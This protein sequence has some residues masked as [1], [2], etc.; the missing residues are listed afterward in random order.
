MYEV[1]S[2]GKDIL[3][4]EILHDVLHDSLSML[5]FLFITYILLEFI[6]HRGFYQ[7][8]QSFLSRRWLGPLLG[9]TLGIIPQCGFSLIASS[10]YVEGALSLG[11]LLAVFISTSDEAIPI[12]LAHPQQASLLP[13]IIFIKLIVA[14]IVGYGVDAL[15]KKKRVRTISMEYHDHTS[16]HGEHASLWK[17][18]MYRTMKIFMF[19]LVINLILTS[20]ITWIGEDT[21]AKLVMDKSF[22]QPFFASLVGFIP[23]CAASVILAQLYS[24]SVLSFGSLMAGLITSAGVGLMVLIKIEKDRKHL[25]LILGILFLSAIITGTFLQYVM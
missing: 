25:I 23:N 16:C 5:P 4:T 22:L 18:A 10:L 17:S 2:K 20:F 24:S 8:Y 6:E 14:M 15:V 9:A 19:V 11:T 21:L 12:L 7:K 13:M 1:F 3:M